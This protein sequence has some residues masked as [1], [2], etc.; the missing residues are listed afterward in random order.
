MSW[1][2]KGLTLLV[3]AL[4]VPFALT[5]DPP[6]KKSHREALKPFN[7]LIGSWRAIGTP[8]GSLQV[9]QKGMWNETMRWEWQFKGDDAWLTVEFNKGKYFVDGELRYLPEK[10]Q[11]QLTIN[12]LD[13]EK[14]VYTG[15]LKSHLL[16]L[17]RQDPKTRDTYRLVISLLHDNRYLYHHEVKPEGKTIFS[18]QYLVGCTKEGVPWVQ[19]SGEIG[20]LCVVSYGPP[21]SPI[22]Y[23]GKTYYVCCSGCRAVFR[24]NP[25]KFIKEYEE[26]IAQMKKE[27]AE[28]NKKP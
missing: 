13:K 6:A 19:T 7:V 28:K 15:E 9:K 18:K 22:T 3:L 16:T 21:T 8:E 12:T 20:P 17:D 1:L 10:N 26:V 5:A 11:F 27:A 25:E 14:L 2:H 23:N 4:L 24:D